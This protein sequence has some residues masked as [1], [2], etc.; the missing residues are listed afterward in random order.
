MWY[1][2]GL[3]NPD[4]EYEN[5]RHNVGRDV[6]NN[7][8]KKCDLVF[9]EDK[10]VRARIAKGKIAGKP[11]M[12]ILPDVAMNNSGRVAR[13]LISKKADA[14]NLIVVRDDIDMG[15]GSTKLTFNRGSGGHR[16][17]E[18]VLEAIKTNEFYQLKIGLLPLSPSGKPKKPKGEKKVVTFVLDE[19]KPTERKEINKEIKKAGEAIESLLTNGFPKTAS[20]FNG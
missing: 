6:V 20:I 13:A 12:L 2:I 4:K 11:A 10:N 17:V 9:K 19:F 8:A 18:S 7:L 14:K 16:G 5:T 15:I 3:G 1:V